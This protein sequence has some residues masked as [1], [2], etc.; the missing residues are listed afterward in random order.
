MVYDPALI[1]HYPYWKGYPIHDSGGTIT[2]ATGVIVEEKDI[3]TEEEKYSLGEVIDV[4]LSLS[5]DD[6]I[7]FEKF[8]LECQ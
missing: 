4:F 5:D 1:Y 6:K 2:T 7:K 3:E 8:I